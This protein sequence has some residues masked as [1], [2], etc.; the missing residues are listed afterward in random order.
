MAFRRPLA[1]SEN[2]Y[3]TWHWQ[4]VWRKS[5]KSK[6]GAAKRPGK[7]EAH[8]A[9]GSFARGLK[10][11]PRTHHDPE[12][13]PWPC[14]SAAWVPSEAELRRS[15]H[16]NHHHSCSRKCCSSYCSRY[17]SNCLRDGPM[18]FGD[19][20]CSSSHNRNCRNRRR[21]SPG[22]NCCHSHRS[23]HSHSYCSR[24]RHIRRSQSRRTS[25]RSLRN[26]RNRCCSIHRHHNGRRDRRTGRRTHCP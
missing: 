2:G 25:N 15:S 7:R 18:T 14:P 16:H 5:S 19:R 9:F 17:C 8:R 22:S 1:Q 12:A 23:H 13:F 24:S 11:S 6:G 26:H 10:S 3:S 20:S 21:S 4:G